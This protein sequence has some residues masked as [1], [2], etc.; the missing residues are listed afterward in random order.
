MQKILSSLSIIAFA[1]IVA[2]SATSAYFSDEETSAGNSFASGTLNLQVSDTDPL[3]ANFNVIDTY[4]GNSGSEDWVLKNTGSIDGSLD[5]TF[6]NLVDAENGV[7]E[8]EYADEGEDETSEC[9][10]GSCVTT[11]ELAEV[12]N[13]LIYIDL[14]NS[15]TYTV[16]DDQLVY[17]GF[18][19]GI[20]T[21]DCEQLSDYAMAAGYDKSIR[22]EWSIADTVDNEI[23]S[24]STGFD[25][26]FELLQI[27]D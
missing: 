20:L 9:V 23:Q 24:D 13:L 4:G 5:I 3:V 15:D 10:T 21:P 19:S 27:A 1:A 17:Q 12:L 16:V 18:A 7:N 2:I 26:G 22:I 6:S 11:G 8:P 25:I 14:N